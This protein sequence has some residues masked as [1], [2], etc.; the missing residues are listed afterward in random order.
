MYYFDMG[1]TYSFISPRIVKKLAYETLTLSYP[2]RIM[3]AR[4]EHEFT[5]LGVQNL[6]FEIQIEAYVWDFVVCNHRDGL[7]RKELSIPKL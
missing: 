7:A 6:E 4:G 5:T 1:C 2:L 3:V